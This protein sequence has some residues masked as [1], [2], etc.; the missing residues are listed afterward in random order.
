M[1]FGLQ[2]IDLSDSLK[3]WSPDLYEVFTYIQT[4][5]SDLKDNALQLV[6][7][8]FNKTLHNGH[9]ARVQCGAEQNF[10]V[11]PNNTLNL[12]V[13]TWLQ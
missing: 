13:L 7:V 2:P 4:K 9:F 3:K 12:V 10:L 5:K 6:T 1:T 8:F 11:R